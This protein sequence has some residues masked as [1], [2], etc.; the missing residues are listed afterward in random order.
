ML[1]SDP[2]LSDG[3]YHFHDSSECEDPLIHE[4][5]QNGQ[6][7]PRESSAPLAIQVDHSRAVQ[8]ILIPQPVLDLC[9]LLR[10]QL[11]PSCKIYNADSAVFTTIVAHL[12]LILKFNLSTWLSAPGHLVDLI[13]SPEP[14]LN[15]VK[16]WHISSMLHLPKLQA[17]IIK[18]YRTYYITCLAKPPSELFPIKLDPFFYLRENVGRNTHAE[19]FLTD[20]FAGLLRGRPKL[21]R[22][23]FE[24]LTSG[25]ASRIVGSWREL[26]NRR[27]SGQDDHSGDRIATGDFEYTGKEG[28]RQAGAEFR[29]QYAYGDPGGR[30]AFTPPVAQGAQG[31]QAVR[32]GTGE[33]R[34]WEEVREAAQ[35]SPD[36]GR[37]RGFSR[38]LEDVR[39]GRGQARRTAG[40]RGE[41]PR[42]LDDV[43]RGN[44]SRARV[45]GRGRGSTLSRL[46][47]NRAGRGRHSGRGT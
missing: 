15:F 27:D 9:P 24:L 34:A 36:V 20:F 41:A 32:L 13:L 16:A 46:A 44:R 2:V 23:D 40:G 19:V 43:R 39:R 42:A 18:V 28:N 8:T 26:R 47:E 37:G 31:A 10:I 6:T 17:D 22:K 11:A 38:L 45:E 25:V 14:L 29:I 35:M 21:D 12:Q 7:P 1:R 33:M 30:W 5:F 4:C 3:Y